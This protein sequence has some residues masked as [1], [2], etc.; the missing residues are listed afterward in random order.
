MRF[1]AVVRRCVSQDPDLVHGP[2]HALFTVDEETT[3]AGAEFL[4][5]PPFLP[6]GEAVL[7]NVDSEMEDAVCVGCVGGAE[8]QI[9][10]ELER[11]AEAPAAADNCQLFRVA[12]SGLLG[13]HSGV[14]IHLQRANGIKI[15]AEVLRAGLDQA[16]GARVLSFS[17]GNA[18]N[19]IPS[20]ASAEVYLPAAETDR[21]REALQKGL[22]VQE[23][24]H[25]SQSAPDALEEK[26][27][28][29]GEKKEIPE[30]GEIRN[31]FKVEV[32]PVTAEREGGR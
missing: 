8:S 9:I 32:L 12:L 28:A 5:G 6:G 21:F 25:V 27:D 24:I 11:E 29:P 3:M 19:A 13:G 31:S 14:D 18:P 10:M 1:L 26:E 7:V 4:G 15:F 20:Y 30:R 2:L 16:R 22:G 17:G 23:R